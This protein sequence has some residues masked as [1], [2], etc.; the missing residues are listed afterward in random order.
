MAQRVSPWLL[1]LLTLPLLLVVPVY[2]QNQVSLIPNPVL[3]EMHEREYTFPSATPLAAFEPF[4]DVASLLYDHPA[5]H[6]MAAERIRSHRR[7]PED[8]VRLIQAREADRLDN[9]AYRL[10]VD[11]SG[12]VIMAH[13]APAMLNGI[14]TILQ[15]AYTQPDGRR[16]PAMVI[17]D[18]PRFGYRGLHLDV[19]RH[20]YSLSFLEKFIDLMALYKFNT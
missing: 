5:V 6:F 15:L 20:F 3:I 13:Q 18:K 9:D 1:G 16:L 4:M 19:S 2:A 8:G 17:E 10:V 7:I 14:L 12:V 11:T